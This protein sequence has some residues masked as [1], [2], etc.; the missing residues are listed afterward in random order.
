[1]QLF[2]T[3]GKCRRWRDGSTVES[4][5]CSSRGQGFVQVTHSHLKLQL[6]VL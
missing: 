1:M 3:K 2:K 6:Q 4:T 5:C